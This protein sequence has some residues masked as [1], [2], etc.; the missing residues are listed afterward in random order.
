MN[1]WLSGSLSLL[2]AASVV[3]AQNAGGGRGGGE[4]EDRIE[5]RARKMRQDLVV[6]KE[7]KSHVRV[8]V[9]LENGNR[10]K[11]VVKDGRLVERV[12]GLRFVDADANDVG[13]GIRLWYSGGTRNYV[14]IPFARLKQ[15]QVLERLSAKELLAIETKMRME[16]TRRHEQLR[17]RALERARAKAIAAKPAGE[18]KPEAEGGQDQGQ[19]AGRGSKPAKDPKNA[20]DA[21]REQYRVWHKLLQDYPPKDGWNAAK[22]DEIKRRFAVIGA[23]PSEFEQRFVDS[24]VEWQKACEQFGAEPEPTPS[25]SGDSERDN[26]RGNKK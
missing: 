26:G 25:E 12:N 9:R 23:R 21:A 3:V 6:G 1:R 7:L 8:Q 18:S 15:Y 17:Q 4:T 10:L 22:R 5:R 16:E 13:A 11:G 2:M 24:F 19:G 20:E 14:F